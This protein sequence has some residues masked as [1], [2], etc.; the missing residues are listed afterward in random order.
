MSHN[1]ARSYKQAGVD[2]EAAEALVERLKPLAAQTR[3]PGVESDL[4]AFGGFFSFPEPGGSRLLIA[5]IDGVG[6]KMKVA[7]LTGDWEGAGYDIVAHCANDILVHGARPLFFLDYIGT[8]SLDL[9]VL[10]ALARGMVA[11]CREARCALLGGETAE[12]PGV[13]HEGEVDL[14]GCI[15]GAVERERLLSG[16]RV[17]PGDLLIG[18]E[19]AG[20]HTNGYSLARRVLIDEGPG[21]GVKVAGTEQLVGKALSARHR[22]YSGAVRDRLERGEL[23]AMAHVTGGGLAGNLSRVIPKGL[24]AVVRRDRWEVPPLF[25]QI[26][27]EGPVSE[28]EM[29]RVFNMGIGWV[30]VVDPAVAPSWREEM[31]REGWGAV[32]IGEVGQAADGVQLV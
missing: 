29:Y 15:I 7:R 21:I 16:E 9:A 18:L 14:V 11:A 23:H 4:G 28:E 17:R 26:Q 13:Y 8:S 25:R 32:I 22:M 30:L 27:K 12:M 10:E 19:S 3:T 24:S 31:E 5:S 6:T 2:I 1:V 20:L